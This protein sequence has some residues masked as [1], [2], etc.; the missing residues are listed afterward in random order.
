M[1]LSLSLSD[2]NDS[3]DS[4]EHS[5]FDLQVQYKYKPDSMSTDFEN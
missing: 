4:S 1:S 3:I 5:L 2:D